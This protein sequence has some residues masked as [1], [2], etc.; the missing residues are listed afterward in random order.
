MTSDSTNYLYPGVVLTAIPLILLNHRISSFY[1]LV[2]FLLFL[3]M[4]ANNFISFT[5]ILP[6]SVVALQRGGLRDCLTSL[7]LLRQRCG[8]WKMSVQGTRWISVFSSKDSRQLVLGYL[9]WG[10]AWSRVGWDMAGRRVESPID[11]KYANVRARHLS[12]IEGILLSYGSKDSLSEQKLCAPRGSWR[13]R[14]FEM[15]WDVPLEEGDAFTGVGLPIKLTVDTRCPKCRS[16]TCSEES[17]IGGFPSDLPC[18]LQRGSCCEKRPLEER[19][20]Y[21]MSYQVTFKVPGGLEGGRKKSRRV[22][23]CVPTLRTALKAYR[24]WLIRGRIIDARQFSGLYGEYRPTPPQGPP[25]DHPHRDVGLPL[26][27]GVREVMTWPPC[28]RPPT[29]GFGRTADTSNVGKSVGGPWPDV[30]IR[31]WTAMVSLRGSPVPSELKGRWTRISLA[32][33]FGR[34]VALRLWGCMINSLA[35]TEWCYDHRPHTGPRF[36]VAQTESGRS[37]EIEMWSQGTIRF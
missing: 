6:E 5:Q 23:R 3:L 24:E 17:C 22:S 31:D 19:P 7:L 9:G 4:S 25:R 2:I 26:H 34:E 29:P 14:C 16:A 18:S 15:G 32:E 20:V 28:E 11:P 21:S 12:R 35:E 36:E 37:L 10:N 33:K 30:K 1:L 13:A 27:W 8:S